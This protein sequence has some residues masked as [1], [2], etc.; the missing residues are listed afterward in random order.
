MRTEVKIN[1]KYIPLWKD[2]SRYFV[3][4]GG[5]GSGKSFG[6]TVFLLLLTYETGHKILFSR[7]TMISANTSI[8]PE[9]IE[10]IEIMGA[11]DEF[12]ITKDEIINLTT[13][14]SIIFKGIRTSSGNQTAALKS[15]NGV[16][17]FVLDEAEELVDES[18]FDKIDFSVRSQEKQNRCVLILN[19]TTKEHWIYQRFFETDG[20]PEGF[21]G[22]QGDV[23]FIHTDYR[24]NKKNLSKSFI[25]QID[26]MKRRRP[27]KYM[28]QILGGWLAKAEGTIIRSWRVGDYIQTEHTCYAQD[29]GF[30]VDPT[31]LVK[32]SVDKDLRKLY[33]KEVYGKP[34]LSTS[35]I[36]H[37]NKMECG[38]DLIICDNSEP[39]LIQELKATGLNIKPTIKKKG[40]ILSGIAL[41]QDYEIIVDRGSNGIVRELNNYVWAEKGERPIDKFNH[42]IDSIRYGLQYLVQGVNSGKYVVR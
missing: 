19:P 2:L 35:E 10:K 40:S 14:S 26:E 17:T 12:R 1:D 42:Y 8:I 25:A 33:V 13:G 31:V 21:N 27:D 29:F 24:D 9:F 11:S 6:V 23:T 38:L 28:H 22:V 5:R 15:L 3:V 37:R 36:A 32:L 30:S 18:V 41:M 16:T 39:R 34:G 4:T 7:Y 20:I